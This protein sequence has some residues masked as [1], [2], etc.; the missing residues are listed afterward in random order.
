MNE[1]A[2]KSAVGLMWGAAGI[3]SGAPT[4]AIG[5]TGFLLGA[6]ISALIWRYQAKKG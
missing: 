3:I 2:I 4:W 1:I 5:V 6:G